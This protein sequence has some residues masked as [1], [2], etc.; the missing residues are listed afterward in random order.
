MLRYAIV[1]VCV[2]AVLSSSPAPAG[3]AVYDL[4]DLG[5]LAFPGGAE[6]CQANGINSSGQVVGSYTNSSGLT[7][8]F[9]YS[10]GSMIN[11][12]NLGAG[13]SG[14]AVATAINSSGQIVGY[15][16]GPQP[17]LAF[18]YSNGTMAPVGN[19][20]SLGV[21]SQALGINDSG[22]VVGTCFGALFT[23]A[24]T[25]R[26][27]AAVREPPPRSTTPACSLAA[28]TAPPSSPSIMARSRTRSPGAR[29]R[30]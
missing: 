27:K 4:T 17:D 3:A 29:A 16:S 21:P 2:C 10:G 5:A 14:A 25:W 13:Y 11:I 8:A 24:A 6:N 28:T 20:Q 23:P 18:L 26:A 19:I 15:A 1:V 9:L 7:C 12:G 22:E 30:P